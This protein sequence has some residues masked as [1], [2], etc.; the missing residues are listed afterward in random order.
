MLEWKAASRDAMQST[1]GNWKITMRV[2]P[3]QG[4]E[5]KLYLR[6]ELRGRLECRNTVVDRTE[7][8]DEL[9]AYA[10]QLVKAGVG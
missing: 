9:K 6:D 7:T 5:Y 1:D 10:E 3:P 2:V 8:L 4:V